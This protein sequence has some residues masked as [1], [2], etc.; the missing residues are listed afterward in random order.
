[1]KINKNTTCICLLLKTHQIILYIPC[2]NYTLFY[3]H[4]MELHLM[5]L[6]K[7]ICY[8]SIF[9]SGDSKNC[10][11]IKKKTCLTIYNRLYQKTNLSKILPCIVN[12]K[13]RSSPT[14]TSFRHLRQFL[15]GFWGAKIIKS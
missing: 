2:K 8:S 4:S 5:K 9:K 1:M 3:K 14:H 13:S 15:C 6:Y 10:K 11:S 12:T 7:Y